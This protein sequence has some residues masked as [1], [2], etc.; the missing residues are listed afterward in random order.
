MANCV[1]TTE[2]SQCGGVNILLQDCQR[3]IT[4]HL[5]SYGI[6]KNRGDIENEMDLILCR[7][8]KQI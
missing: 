4:R 6:G 1:F 7:A 3:D 8:G 5:Q 2:S